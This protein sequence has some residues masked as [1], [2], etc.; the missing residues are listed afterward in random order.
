MQLRATQSPE[1]KKA[2]ASILYTECRKGTVK[3]VIEKKNKNGSRVQYL[4]VLWDTFKTPSQHAR[5]RLM[6]LDK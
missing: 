3:A 4:D 5:N 1:A 6:H 2:Q